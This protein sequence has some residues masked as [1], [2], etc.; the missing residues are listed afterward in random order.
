MIKL[1]F[2]NKIL[3]KPDTVKI[4]ENNY[5]KIEDFNFILSHQFQFG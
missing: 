5:L 1:L 4:Y 3:K 2:K